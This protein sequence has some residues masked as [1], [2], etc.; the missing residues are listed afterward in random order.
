MGDSATSLE[1]PEVQIRDPR[2]VRKALEDIRLANPEGLLVMAEVVEAA[3]DESSPLHLFFN[4]DIALAAY[5][6]WLNQARALVRTIEV[7]MPDDPE[8]S[9]IPRYIS[10]VS[11]RKRNGGGYRE[12]SQVFSNKELMEELE[13]TAKKDVEAVL[14]RY[15]M[16]TGF[17]ARI[18]KVMG[19]KRKKQ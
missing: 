2:A 12:A 6:H 3:R 7:I 10:L 19:V 16:L 1:L 8:E 9:L 11:D 17:V 14:R 18:R 4:W 15:Q 5:Q 13:V